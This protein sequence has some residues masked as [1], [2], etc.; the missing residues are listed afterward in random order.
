MIKVFVRKHFVTK[1]SGCTQNLLFLNASC[2]LSIGISKSQAKFYH[3]I[4]R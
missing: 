4:I 3:A 2:A 1:D